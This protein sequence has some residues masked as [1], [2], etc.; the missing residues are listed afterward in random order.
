MRWRELSRVAPAGGVVARMSPHIRRSHA[1]WNAGSSHANGTRPRSYVINA[2]GWTPQARRRRRGTVSVYAEI[3]GHSSH[4]RRGTMQGAER[5]RLRGMFRLR[6]P[7]DSHP[8]VGTSRAGSKRRGTH[9]RPS[10]VA[11]RTPCLRSRGLGLSAEGACG[12][13]VRDDFR[14]SVFP[15]RRRKRAAL[16]TANVCA[17]RRAH[18]ASIC[19]P[20]GKTAH[21]PPKPMQ[22]R[23][24]G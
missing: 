13:L 10:R 17:P 16:R 1:W 6:T 7:G 12:G 24:A 4:Q 8:G 21:A 19:N 9:P 18:A 20:V 15:A 2:L 23:S 3:T 22:H 14:G 11:S 5:V